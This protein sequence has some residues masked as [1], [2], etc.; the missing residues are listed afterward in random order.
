MPGI[1]DFKT[2]DKGLLGSCR[3][4]SG[5]ADIQNLSVQ[6]GVTRDRLVELY[7]NR[8]Q[9]TATGRMLLRT[10]AMIFD[11]HLPSE[12]SDKRYSQTI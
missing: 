2:S 6:I 8:I 1:A 4:L 5:K 9:I 7:P 10:V 11:R 3:P 12:G